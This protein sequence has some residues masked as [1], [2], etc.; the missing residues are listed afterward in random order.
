MERKAYSDPL[1][2]VGVI[3]IGRN[4]GARLRLA[5]SSVVGSG[6]AAVYYV[7]SGS[8]DGS[9]EL[10]SSLGVRVHSLSADRP[11]SAARARREGVEVLLRDFPSVHLIQFV[12]GDCE[13]AEQW[14]EAACEAFQ[15]SDDVAIVCGRLAES[16]PEASVYNRLS[17]LQWRAP[18]GDIAA[19][20][21]IFMIR[22]SAYEQ[23]GGFNA[24][25]VTREEKDLCDRVHALGHRV[26]RIDAMMAWHDAGLLRFDQWWRRAVWGGYGDA[27]QIGERSGPLLAS[28]RRRIRRY[29]TWP[30]VVP[31]VALLGLLASWWWLGFLLL[32]A[33]GILAYALQGVRMARWRLRSGDSVR[34]ALTYASMRTLRR[35][36]SGY[37]FMLYFLGRDQQGRRPDPHRPQSR[38]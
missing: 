21:G 10:A 35:F 16:H 18:I 24:A 29:L 19:C 2:R 8:T 6:V 14:L 17:D 25:L 30:V 13:L 36:A 5:L 7:D 37:G 22:R 23:A 4:E 28:H 31:L 34:E 11:F 15:Q 33:F 12:D 1:S 38:S 9:I 27:V 20:G 3:V 26:V 32:P